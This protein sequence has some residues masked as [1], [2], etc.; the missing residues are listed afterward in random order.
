MVSF[1][2]EVVPEGGGGVPE[3][4]ARLGRE[5]RRRLADLRLSARQLAD[6]GYMPRATLQRLTAGS[7]VPR[8][9]TGL[10][11]GL[12]WLAGSADR[13]VAG[14]EPIVILVTPAEAATAP[15]ASV[16]DWPRPDE[17]WKAA[18]ESAWEQYERQGDAEQQA[19]VSGRG[20]GHDSQAEEAVDRW[21]KPRSADLPVWLAERIRSVL[22]ET[23][24]TP[25][26]AGRADPLALADRIMALDHSREV[27]A[28]LI[29]WTRQDP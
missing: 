3:G 13:V 22:I 28:L 25:G 21:L 1:R 10:E 6:A 26:G 29:E 18:I 12:G 2:G 14:G 23:A 11:R 4:A 27:L 7:T 20:D 17:S 15:G 8:D 5:V 19:T 24:R 9:L 16:I